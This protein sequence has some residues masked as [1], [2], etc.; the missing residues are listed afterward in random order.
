MGVS[1][2][3]PLIDFIVSRGAIAGLRIAKE[4]KAADVQGVG[5][6][7]YASRGK[8]EVVLGTN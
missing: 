8:G 5:A 3:A 2:T 1:A 6:H 4:S 7:C